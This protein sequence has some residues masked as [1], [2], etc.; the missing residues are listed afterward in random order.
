M[1]FKQ[2][3]STRSSRAVGLAAGTFEMRRVLDKLCHGK[4]EIERRKSSE[5]LQDVYLWRRLLH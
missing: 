4:A 5:N 2:V 3:Q 1:R